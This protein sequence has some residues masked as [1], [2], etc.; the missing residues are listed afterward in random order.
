MYTILS[1]HP[2][3][4]NICA[5]PLYSSQIIDSGDL[6]VFRYDAFG[7]A[8]GFDTSSALT[9]HLYNSEPFDGSTGLYYFRARY[10]RPATGR[11]LTTDPARGNLN[12]E[13]RIGTPN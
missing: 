9:T 2:I 13:F 1:R 4:L 10:Y 11:L 6:Q 5:C 8:I 12:P 7:N 3:I